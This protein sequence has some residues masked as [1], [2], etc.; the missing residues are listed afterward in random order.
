MT[1]EEFLLKLRE[2]FAV[3][4]AEHL[5]AITAGVL[6]LE[7]APAAELVETTFREAHSLK[8]AAGA[9]NRTDMAAV[10][11]AMESVL[12]Q[13][14]RNELTVTPQTFDVLN[15]A[16]DLLG[17]LLQLPDVSTGAAERNEISTMVSDLGALS[18]P[19]GAPAAQAA[20]TAA[21]LA[22]PVPAEAPSPSPPA[23]P[24]TPALEPAERVSTETAV[25]IPIAKMDAL[26]RR[27]EEMIAVK[28]TSGRTA[29]KLRGLTGVL[30]GWR[31]EWGKAR[32]AHGAAE[33]SNEVPA[34]RVA[35]FLEWNESF[36]HSL[37]G[38]L[39]E[40]AS[41]AA[42]DERATGALVDDLLDEAK[43]LVMLP[44]GTLLDVFPKLVRDLARAQGKEIALRVA[45]REVEID[46]RIL[47]EMKDPMIHLVRNSI[48]HGLEKPAERTAAGKPAGGT[49]AIS[50]TQREGN[51]VE[52]VVAD[53]GAGI[54]VEQVKAT[55]VRA[56]TLTAEGAETLEEAAA[57]ALIFQSGV[58]TSPIITELSG[59]GL[60]MAIV[61]EKVERLGGQI[62]IE[63]ARGAGT[64]FR[65]L[66]PVTLATFKGILV[67]AGGQTLVIPTSQVER[68]MRVRRD[69]VG[70]VEN[71]ETIVCGGQAVALARLDE[72][73]ELAPR[74]EAGAFLELVVLGT[75]E[76]RI[77][78]VVEAVLHEQEVLVKEIG[79]PLRR[80]RNV[81]GATVL[82]SGR[83]AIILNTDDLL[84]SAVRLAASGSRRAAAPVATDKAKRTRRILV[85]DDSI[86]SRMLLKNIL[87]SSGYVV[88]TAV[89]G[90]EALTALKSREFD[91]LVSDVEMPRLD[92]FDLTA[93]VRAEK[94]LAEL[95]VVLVTA[96][97]S[98]EHQERGIDVGASAYVVKSSFDR[99]NLLE[100]VRKLI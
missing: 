81:A 59:R 87:E 90:M 7:Q 45:G 91:L 79:A 29:A 88:E 13:W 43:R 8:G 78:F 57:V 55:A 51:K 6:Q 11:Q 73:L 53:D 99:G 96:L 14:K 46:K 49:L 30:A 50:V 84:R 42:R 48:D 61:R 37:E 4:A 72:V 1:D 68:I 19:G 98:R 71:R 32:L 10:C 56:G 69:E 44:C 38:R 5:E 21:D 60:G 31:K 95:P 75:A 25:R 97:G 23:V 36:M 82:G 47:Q 16:V 28:L 24:A 18:V 35:E 65:I 94:K 85:A 34:E 62:R 20:Q 12:A 2:A 58:S 17:R 63:T 27:A 26:L 92:G 22:R 41:S 74:A 86:T 40:L 76:K 77:A 15:R 66:L 89:D 39:A 93:K 67:S 70:T 52:I 33:G 80:V 83:P 54:D 3:E 100:I 64:K 9:V